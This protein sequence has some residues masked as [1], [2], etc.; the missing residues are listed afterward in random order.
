MKT[1]KEDLHTMDREID[2]PVLQLLITHRLVAI[3]RLDD[4]GDAVPLAKV[5]VEAG[6]KA[7]EFTLTNQ[8]APSSIRECLREIPEF[9]K[10]IAAIGMG[11][12]RSL[13]E[14]RLAVECGAQFVVCPV[15]RPEVIHHCRSIRIPVCPGAYTPTEIESAWS[16]G[17]DIVKVFPARALGPDYIKDVLAPMPYL[18]LMPT[19]GVDL[20]NVESYFLAGAVAVGVGGQFLDKRAIAHRNWSVI[21]ES[22]K[23]FVDVCSRTA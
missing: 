10:G 1:R 8:A 9:R 17:A 23:R 22:A 20:S 6:V 21:G 19:G 2:N 4:L 14:A 7:L 11:S 16:A 18:R 3:L 12:V 13:E 5:L 15:T